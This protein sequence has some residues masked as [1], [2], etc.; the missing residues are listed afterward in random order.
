MT[1]ENQLRLT[2]A[3]GWKTEGSEDEVVAATQEHG[4]AMHNMEVTRERVL[5]M[6]DAAD[7]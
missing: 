7:A 1:E 6:A 4:R 3:C 2:C 5:E